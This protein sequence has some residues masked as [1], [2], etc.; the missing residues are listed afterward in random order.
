MPR[1][2]IR[3]NHRAKAVRKPGISGNPRKPAPKSQNRNVQKSDLKF[4]VKGSATVRNSQGTTVHRRMLEPLRGRAV[5]PPPIWLMRQAGRFLP[6]YRATRAEAGSFLDL[7]YTPELA[8]E[9]TLQPIRRFGF[10]ASIIFSDILVVPHALGQHLSFADGEGPRLEPIRD[11]ASLA[12][13]RSSEDDAAFCAGLG[14]GRARAARTPVRDDA[15]RVLRRA[16][17]GCD[18]HGRG[19][20]FERS[21]GG[22]QLGLSGSGG[23]SGAYRRHRGGVRR[24]FERPG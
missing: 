14:N 18:V 19:T 21:V 10:D 17:D 13:T 6:E 4:E 9:V 7:C 5:A 23:F 8:A 22:A 15:D 12:R 2:R 20:G 16:L 24:I 11:L 1:P 3:G